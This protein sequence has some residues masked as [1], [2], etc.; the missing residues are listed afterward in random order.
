MG[1][2][3]VS[4]T[5]PPTQL[6]SLSFPRFGYV[7]FTTAEFAKAALKCNNKDLDGRS[8][9]I[10][11]SQP[12]EKSAT[13]V[14]E[15]PKSSPSDTIFVANLSYKM[16]EVKLREMFEEMG[17]VLSVRMPSDRDTGKLKG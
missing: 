1:S 5:S 16:N 4:S 10:D 17:E 12:K 9:R 2:L 3:T 7:E 15:A 11:L 8:I 14:P 13:R 6:V